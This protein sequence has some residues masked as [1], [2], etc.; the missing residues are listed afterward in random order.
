MARRHDFLFLPLLALMLWPVPARGDD[1]CSIDNR[2][3]ATLLLPYFEIDPSKPSG[4]TTLFSINNAAPEAVMTL[5]TVWTDMGVPTL[6]FPIYLTG[7]DVQTINLRDFFD[8]V[9][10]QTAPED[11]DPTDAI[12]P[13]GHSFGAQDSN[14]ANCEA[15]LPLPPALPPDFVAHLRAA[16]SGKFSGLLRGCAGQDLGDGHLRGYVTVDTVK[17]CTL[18][19]PGDVGYFGPQGVVSNQ[20]VLWGD[21]LYLDPDH[22]VSDGENLVHIKAF[23]GAF[24]QGDLTFYGRYVGMSGADE[25]Q[26]LPT[27]WA[28]RYV[29]GAGFSGGTDLVVWRDGGRPMAPFSC[30]TKPADFPL[31][32]DQEITFNEQE[33]LFFTTAN[34]QPPG[35]SRFAI[36]VEANRVHVGGPTF[37]VYLPFGWIFLDLNA[38][39]PGNPGQV[40][41]QSWVQTILTAE[42]QFSAGFSA[43]PLASPCAPKSPIP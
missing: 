21:Y 28:S 13:H 31:G 43:T 34:P 26:P 23:P 11:E 2:P 18:R 29:N 15:L 39:P 35:V 5:V 27:A 6:V 36:P 4:L 12:S 30:G 37:P 8:G 3:A 1:L 10:P 16:N 24:H 33:S 9:L 40:L 38:T 7:Y 20:N 19:Q 17:E 32:H 25:R 22:K 41:R 42:G 14:F